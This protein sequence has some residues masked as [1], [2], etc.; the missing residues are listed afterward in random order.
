MS[1]AGAGPTSADTNGFN[2]FTFNLGEQLVC[3][4]LVIPCAPLTSSQISRDNADPYPS[5]EEFWNQSNRD[6]T[7]DGF[8]DLYRA[9]FIN[10]VGRM[11]RRK[12]E[13]LHASPYHHALLRW[14]ISK[15]EEEEDC[16]PSLCQ[17][18]EYTGAI[19]VGLLEI[20]EE[21]TH[22]YEVQVSALDLAVTDMDER[23]QDSERRL[24]NLG[25]VEGVVQEVWQMAT[26]A[27][28]ATENIQ[29]T[30]DWVSNLE[31]RMEDA[32]VVAMEVDEWFSEVENKINELKLDMMMLVA[33]RESQGWDLQ[34]I[35]DVVVD[36]QGLIIQLQDQIDLLREQVLELQHGAANPIV[37]EEYEL[38]TDSDLES[39]GME[40]MDDD[41]SEVIMY[42]LAP[43]GL[44]VPIKDGETTAVS[45]AW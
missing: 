37:I 43:P 25:G 34:W 38:E 1:T 14:G 7:N 45:S 29:A 8:S 19:G 18:M 23:V 36:Q 16:E 21:S 33:C 42:Y 5:Y 32:E 2:T 39:E 10:A 40:V 11:S 6:Q 26:V 28:D 9:N 4:L 44:L 12:L 17:G 30:R 35:W 31:G 22:R 24:V 41:D 15:R 27:R 20:I 3:P 13:R